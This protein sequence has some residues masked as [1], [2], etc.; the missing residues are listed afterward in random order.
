MIVEVK[1]ANPLDPDL[2]GSS[3][4]SQLGINNTFE[5]WTHALDRVTLLSGTLSTIELRRHLY[6]SGY[7]PSEIARLQQVSRVAVEVTIRG[8]GRAPMVEVIRR[9]FPDAGY[10]WHKV[11]GL[12]KLLKNG[13]S[14]SQV[15]AL[16]PPF[17]EELL[18]NKR[19]ALIEIGIVMLEL[20][21]IPAA[22]AEKKT[23][24]PNLLNESLYGRLSELIETDFSSVYERLHLAGFGIEHRIKHF[25]IPSGEL[26]NGNYYFFPRNE[27]YEIRRFLAGGRDPIIA[28]RVLEFIAEGNLE[29][30]PYSSLTEL[31]ERLGF[32]LLHFTEDGGIPKIEPGTARD[33]YQ[34]FLDG[35]NTLEVG[36]K[37]PRVWSRWN[38]ETKKIW[39]KVQA[40]M[41]KHGGKGMFF[42]NTRQK[43][44]RSEKNLLQTSV[45]ATNS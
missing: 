26:K 12:V 22:K 44:E 28:R 31:C 27:E 2:V 33:Y 29:N 6:I 36:V 15:A 37:N 3:L 4:D 21:Q 43:F 1:P 25:H 38:E 40:M 10:E 8:L 19:Q 42:I 5:G 7:R 9:L 45:T 11:I 34:Y 41:R 13:L 39:E 23:S 35:F 20:P 17:R 16:H 32:S 14:P 18:A 30:Y 24:W